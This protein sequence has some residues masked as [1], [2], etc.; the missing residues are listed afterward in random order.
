MGHTNHL[1][2]QIS[3]LLIFDISRPAPAVEG[4]QN[5]R[6]LHTTSP[7]NNP[8]FL[9]LDNFAKFC[10]RSRTGLWPPTGREIVSI[11]GKAHAPMAG[12]SVS[13]VSTDPTEELTLDKVREMSTAKLHNL[14]KAQL[15]E[16]V[17]S[18]IGH[19]DRLELHLEK[20]NAPHRQQDLQAQVGAQGVKEGR[21]RR[22]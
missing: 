22:Q 19:I 20:N 12:S 5:P 16:L 21:L 11:V 14:K 1:Y 13:S 7:N 6:N 4:N 18:F 2:G 17:S 8:C 3:R 9:L 10:F 15:V